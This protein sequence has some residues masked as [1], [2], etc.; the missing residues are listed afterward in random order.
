M[1]MNFFAFFPLI[2]AVRLSFTN[3]KS[4][5]PNAPLRFLELENYADILSDPDV[6]HSMQV[7]AHFVVWTIV[8]QMLLG[9]GSALLINRKFR[10]HAFWTTVILL[11]MML[12]PPPR[13]SATSRRS[14]SSRRSAWRP[15][16]SSSWIPGY[17]RPTSC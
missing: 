12:S 3:Y 5:R 1:Q 16:R 10:G 15:G 14:C 2:W 4:N 17:G 8:L 7:T 9:L 6:W 13:W 11:P